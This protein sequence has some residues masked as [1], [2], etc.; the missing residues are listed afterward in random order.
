MA[1]QMP[2]TR[3]CKV[4]NVYE[5]IVF[6][7]TVKPEPIPATGTAPGPY[8]YNCYADDGSESDFVVACA[9]EIIWHLWVD[10]SNN[11]RYITPELQDPLSSKG[12]I[13]C[14]KGSTVVRGGAF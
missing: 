11:S 6:S 14:P 13:T 9:Q 2:P 1:N 4:V 5:M 8:P 3:L 7:G 12:T 10:C